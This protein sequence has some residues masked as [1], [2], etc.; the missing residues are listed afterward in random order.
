MTRI[1]QIVSPSA[2][3][4]VPRI[5]PP[6][7]LAPCPAQT[8]NVRRNGRSRSCRGRMACSCGRS[9]RRRSAPWRLRPG[10]SRSM[11]CP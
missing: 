6:R 2:A 1:H 3:S 4:C 8:S 7:S 11:A 10:P 5:S 9:R